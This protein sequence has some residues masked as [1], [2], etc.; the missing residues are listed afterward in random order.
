MSALDPNLRATG[1]QRDLQPNGHRLVE[2]LCDRF[3]GDVLNS[4]EQK[5]DL[6]MC[7]AEVS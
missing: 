3:R 4:F 2:E 1:F 5:E 6:P 7:K